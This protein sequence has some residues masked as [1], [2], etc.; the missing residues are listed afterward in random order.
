MRRARC[1]CASALKLAEACPAQ[2]EARRETLHLPTSATDEDCDAVEARALTALRGAASMGPPTMRIPCDSSNG[3][4]LNP[5][6]A[7]RY[8]AS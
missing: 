6:V 2:A 1:A 7:A 8:F 5:S 4:S 3:R